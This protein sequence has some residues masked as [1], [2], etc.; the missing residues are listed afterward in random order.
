LTDEMWICCR[1]YEVMRDQSYIAAMQ[2]VPGSA[3][4]ASQMSPTQQPGSPLQQLVPPANC[5]SHRV[6]TD[7]TVSR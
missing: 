4:S 2:S 1:V 7:D 5:A 3:A 6:S